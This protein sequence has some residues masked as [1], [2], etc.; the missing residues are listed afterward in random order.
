MIPERYKKA[1][2]GPI[3]HWSLR[4]S[5]EKSAI[6]IIKKYY[7]NIDKIRLLDVGCAQGREAKCFFDDGVGYVEGV[8]SNKQFIDIATRQYPI[9]KF[10]VGNAEGLSFEDDAF[11]VVFCVNTLFYT[12]VKKSLNEIKRVLKPGGI[13]IITLDKKIIDLDKNK[14]IH[15]LN[16]NDVLSLLTNS[17]VLEKKYI[18]RKDSQP[19]K[20]KHHYFLIVFQKLK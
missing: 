15:Q 1:V 4:K 13:G 10:S 6:S 12:N 5:P 2:Y 7:N 18:E 16:V 17:K 3:C 14:V 11:D 19:F 20:H 9:L 8:D